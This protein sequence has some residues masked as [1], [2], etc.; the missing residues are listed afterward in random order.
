MIFISCMFKIL[1]SVFLFIREFEWLLAFFIYFI[2]LSYENYKILLLIIVKFSI[3]IVL[4]THVYARWVE[5]MHAEVNTG[6]KRRAW[7][8]QLSPP[9]LT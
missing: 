5:G 3:V 2:G 1:I 6:G 4:V 7:W 9:A 8:S